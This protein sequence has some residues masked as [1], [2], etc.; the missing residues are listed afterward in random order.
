MKNTIKIY[1]KRCYKECESTYIKT[2]VKLDIQLN[3]NICKINQ[4]IPKSLY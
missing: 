2:Y 1:E 3:K 4:N